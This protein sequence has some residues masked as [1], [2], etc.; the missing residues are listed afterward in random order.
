M[1][2]VAALLAT[3]AFQSDSGLRSPVPGLRYFQQSVRYTIAAGL[4]EPS[5]TLGGIARLDYRNNSPDTLRENYFH[6]YLNAFRPGS[7]WSADEQREGID[8]FAHLPE[9]WN[10]FEHLGSVTVDGT[11]VTPVFPN[12]PDSTIVRFLL[13]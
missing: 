11:P 7:L 2:S 13:P 1:L 8:R 6:L 9:P 4:D 12:A 3:V 10:A 5:G